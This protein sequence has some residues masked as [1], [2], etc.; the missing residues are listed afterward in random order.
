MK[1]VNELLFNNASSAPDRKDL[2]ISS[3]I[4]HISAA[5]RISNQSMMIIDFDDHIPL[6]MSNNMIYLNEALEGDYKRI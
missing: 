3:M 4:S 2:D 6:Y 1:D 5:S